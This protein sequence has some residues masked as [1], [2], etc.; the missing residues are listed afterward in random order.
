MVAESEKFEK[1]VMKGAGREEG[2]VS[3]F[4]KK[5]GTE[6]TAHAYAIG[7][8]CVTLETKSTVAR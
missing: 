8:Y 5:T 7:F 6:N 1:V 3:E 4:E 2:K